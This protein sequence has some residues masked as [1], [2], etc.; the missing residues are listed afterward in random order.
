MCMPCKI[1][2]SLGGPIAYVK[3]RNY[4]GSFCIRIL[5]SHPFSING[6]Y[7]VCHMKYAQGAHF[8]VFWQ[9]LILAT[10]I[11]IYWQLHW[12]HYGRDGVSN[13]Q[14]YDCLLNHLCRR[15]WKKTSK[16]LVT[17]LRAGNSPVTGEFPTQRASNAENGSIWGRHHGNEAIW[18]NQY[19]RSNSGE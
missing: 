4:F 16:L 19:G 1:S 11:N 18:L 13:H 17:D 14:P 8:A 5:F 2:L 6:W 10:Y 15:R 3:N 9:K 12:R 7:S